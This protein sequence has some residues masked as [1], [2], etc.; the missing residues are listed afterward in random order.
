MDHGASAFSKEVADEEGTMER[1]TL[2][3]LVESGHTARL[4]WHLSPSTWSNP[5]PSLEDHNIPSKHAQ[6]QPFYK[7]AEDAM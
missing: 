6:L 7:K 2:L 4:P 3:Q 1:V 5:P